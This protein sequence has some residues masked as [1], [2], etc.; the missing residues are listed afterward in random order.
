MTDFMNDICAALGQVSNPDNNAR[1]NAE[2]FLKQA[3]Y[4]QG[5]IEGLLV[6]S[7]SPDVSKNFNQGVCQQA[8]IMLKLLV[9]ESYG[10]KETNKNRFDPIN[11]K[12]NTN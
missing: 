9:N 12:N 4:Q 11:N 6:I 8:S 7:T 2:D 10:P 5:C 3:R 1:A